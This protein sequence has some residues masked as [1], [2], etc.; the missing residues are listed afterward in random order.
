MKTVWIV[1]RGERYE[2]AL[3]LGVFGRKP[4]KN[5]ILALGG[6]WDW[7]LVREDSDTIVYEHSCD[8]LKA[9]RFAVR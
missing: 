4:S 2:G 9:E 3:I 5:H 6:Q 1:T 7:E 8:I